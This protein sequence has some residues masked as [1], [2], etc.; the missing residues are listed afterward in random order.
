MNTQYF[1]PKVRAGEARYTV[2]GYWYQYSTTPEYYFVYD[3]EKSANKG[4]SFAT[5]E[6]A[7]AYADTLNS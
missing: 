2:E 6:L 3:N 1:P 7:Q 5:K 4:G